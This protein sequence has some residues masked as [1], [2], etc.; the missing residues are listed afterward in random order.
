MTTR[1]EEGRLHPL[2]T[3]RQFHVSPTPVPSNR[4]STTLGK[5]VGYLTNSVNWT[6]CFASLNWSEYPSHIFWKLDSADKNSARNLMHSSSNSTLL[7][8]SFSSMSI[9]SAIFVRV[10]IQSCL[11]SN[12]FKCKLFTKFSKVCPSEH[13]RLF[14]FVGG[15]MFFYLH[16][17]RWHVLYYPA[18]P[19]RGCRTHRFWHV[20][21]TWGC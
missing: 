7:H 12:R 19:H 10:F 3:F 5:S 15:V 6:W 2:S 21:R 18:G 1:L 4:L 14:N 17:L 11:L 13:L 20:Q 16:V 8:Q 9:C